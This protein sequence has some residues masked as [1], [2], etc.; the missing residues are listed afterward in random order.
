MSSNAQQAFHTTETQRREWAPGYERPDVLKRRPLL[1]SPSEPHPMLSALMDEALLRIMLVS[2]GAVMALRARVT[3]S[4][5]AST[6]SSDLAIIIDEL[7]E[8][9]GACKT[10]RRRIVVIKEAQ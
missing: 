9:Y 8:H 10:H 1:D 2:D 3:G 5:S 7:G 6:P 4:R